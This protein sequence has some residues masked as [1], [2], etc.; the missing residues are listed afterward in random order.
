MVSSSA[1]NSKQKSPRVAFS[2]SKWGIGLF[3]WLKSQATAAN[4]LVTNGRQRDANA[5]IRRASSQVHAS[6]FN[7]GILLLIIP[8]MLFILNPLLESRLRIHGN[9]IV[10]TSYVDVKSANRDGKVFFC[11]VEFSFGRDS[12]DEISNIHKA[13]AGFMVRHL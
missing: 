5:R 12:L 13:K 9:R 10:T 8:I 6:N 2:P 1:W 7:R 11:W 3:F 4:K